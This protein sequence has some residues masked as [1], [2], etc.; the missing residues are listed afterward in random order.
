MTIKESYWQNECPAI[1]TT[2]MKEANI[3]HNL[4]KVLMEYEKSLVIICRWH[5]LK[6]ILVLL[7]ESTL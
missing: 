4:F 1:N 3:E 7:L 6:K 2:Q 5:H